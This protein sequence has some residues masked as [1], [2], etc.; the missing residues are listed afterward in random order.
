MRKI[1]GLY[2][3]KLKSCHI[4]SAIM[5]V[6][7]ACCIV[8]CDNDE[9][10]N[11]DDNEPSS[12]GLVTASEL[13]GKWTLVKDN[14]LYSQENSSKRDEVITYSGNSAPRYHFYNVTVSDDDVIS[15]VEVSASGSVIGSPIQ[16]ELYGN[17]L[18]T[19]DGKV[20]GT[21]LH[22]DKGHSWDNLRIEWDK[23][24]SPIS[25]NSAVISTYM[26]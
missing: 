6:L 9:P 10:V 16:L 7:M 19:L 11:N 4:L 12:V 13:A 15:I 8:S 1:Q 2:V 18:K 14:V 23:D 3:G 17:D 5:A 20:A 25:F 22:Y 24:Y 21:V 26:L